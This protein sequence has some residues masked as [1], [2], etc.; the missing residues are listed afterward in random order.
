MQGH[1]QVVGGYFDIS[2][3]ADALLYGSDPVSGSAN[4]SPDS[5]GY[6]MQGSFFPWRNVQVQAQYTAYTKFNGA[7]NNY[8]G[9]GRDASD[10]NTVYLLGW[11]LW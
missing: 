7:S 10:N 9:N 6:V 3:D 1:W 4:G 11:F 8:D 2:G 5:S